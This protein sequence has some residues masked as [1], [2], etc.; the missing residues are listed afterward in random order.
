MYW[1]LVAD[2]SFTLN[3][4]SSTETNYLLELYAHKGRKPKLSSLGRYFFLP[5]LI[6]YEKPPNYEKN[7][8]MNSIDRL[9]L[10]RLTD[11]GSLLSTSC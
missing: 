10:W 4:L 1:N 8:M 7:T 9:D 6:R 11:F 3:T 5:T 2:T